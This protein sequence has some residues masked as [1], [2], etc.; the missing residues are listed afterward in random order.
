MYQA[1]ESEL[2]KNAYLRPCSQRQTWAVAPGDWGKV[3]PALPAAGFLPHR[4]S[5]FGV[6]DECRGQLILN[7]SVIYVFLIRVLGK[8][9]Y[10]R[11]DVRHAYNIHSFRIHIQVLLR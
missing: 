9:L 8:S 4:F 6:F 2:I 5:L 3:A 10:L 7:L 11:K 1:F